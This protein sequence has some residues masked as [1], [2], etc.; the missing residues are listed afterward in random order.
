MRPP[1]TP[2]IN[3]MDADQFM[4]IT[5]EPIEITKDMMTVAEL[6]TLP[7]WISISFLFGSVLYTSGSFF[8]IIDD[9]LT[10][11]DYFALVTVAFLI[12]GTAFLLG[13]Y[14][15]FYGII[16]SP[17]P[18]EDLKGHKKRRRFFFHSGKKTW[19]YYIALIYMFGTTCFY[20]N[21]LQKV[22]GI[23]FERG[24]AN[25]YIRMVSYFVGGFCFWYGGILDIY[26]NW[27]N[28]AKSKLSW[29]VS[30]TNMI[31]GFMFFLGSIGLCGVDR[32]YV[33][34]LAEMPYIIGSVC[35]AITSALGLWNNEWRRK[36][37]GSNYNVFFLCL[38][39]V[40]LA[41]AMTAIVYASLCEK[42]MDWI[43]NLALS[44]MVSIA[45]LAMGV[46]MLFLTVNL[47]VDAY[48]LSTLSGYGCQGLHSIAED[49]EEYKR[50]KQLYGT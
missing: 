3:P 50:F 12:G 44:A 47:M 1:L 23:Y 45:V 35:Y 24:T 32:W 9:Y 33:F 31:G 36:K 16:N 10:E 39:T 26:S 18:D 5:I 49:F 21:S 48:H 13:G 46:F 43:K 28:A 2:S 7:Y 20:V 42:Y 11:N 25:W 37:H 6:E 30:W 41:I 34:W 27:H 14:M 29:F 15:N 8:W 17:D 40:T 38:Y 19:S 4:E 22:M